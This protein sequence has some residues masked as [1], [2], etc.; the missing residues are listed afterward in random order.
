MQTV[1]LLDFRSI[2]LLDFFCKIMWQTLKGWH[3]LWSGFLKWKQWELVGL[4]W[5]NSV[6]LI[7]NTIAH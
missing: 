6:V 4:G 7:A 1:V 2:V 3:Q 5:E